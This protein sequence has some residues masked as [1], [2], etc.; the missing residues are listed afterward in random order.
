[1]PAAVVAATALSFAGGASAVVVSGIGGRSPQ[2]SAGAVR[3]AEPTVGDQTTVPASTATQP[4]AAGASCPPVRPL[5]GEPRQLVTVGKKVYFTADDGT[6]GRELWMS[7]GTEQ[8]TVMVRNI[9]P[10][11]AR[12]PGS[13]PASLTAFRGRLFFAAE[14]GANGRELWA[15]DGTRVGSAVVKDIAPKGSSSP[16]E[17]MRLGGQLFFGADDGTHGRELW[18]TDGSASGTALVRDIVTNGGS[19]PGSEPHH[20]APVDGHLLF[21]A[22]IREQPLWTSDGTAEGTVPLR[23]TSDQG[24]DALLMHYP[25]YLTA[26]R[27]LLIFAAGMDEWDADENLSR[28]GRPWPGRELWRSDGT[29]AG[30]VLVKDINTTVNNYGAQSSFPMELTALGDRVFF[31]AED[32]VHGRELWRTDGTSRGTQLIKDVAP[33]RQSSSDP[34]DLAAVRKRVF[35]AAGDG[36]HGRELWVSDGTRGGTTMVEDVNAGGPPSSPQS[37][38]AFRQQLFFTAS[39]GEHGRELWKSDG[40]PQGTRM[41][42]DIDQCD[43]TWRARRTRPAALTV[44]GDR[45]FFAA[46]DGI[47]GKELWVSDGTA[48]G[49]R[50]VEDIRPGP[51]P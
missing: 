32:G 4:S 25:D 28:P 14:D 3:P 7:D 10:D 38:T 11:S 45:L 18:R 50:L 44:V 47:H 22:E 34:N 49:T 16:S 21:A 31:S 27:G 13:R 12:D 35:F 37:L 5:A 19:Y 15:S 26:M 24:S 23:S 41:V 39:D 30:T 42:K 8:G 29:S 40:T 51:G 2:Q 46:D 36:V 20:L 33:S 6:H 17:L 1:M 9:K 43:D 48:E